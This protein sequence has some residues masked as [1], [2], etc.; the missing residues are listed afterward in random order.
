MDNEPFNAIEWI[1]ANRDSFK[2]PTGSR[3]ISQDD[4][5]MVMLLAGPNAR[6]DYHINPHGEIFHQLKGTISVGYL[7]DQGLQQEAVIDE[8]DVW[9]CPAFVPHQ[10]RRPPGTY[11]LVIE[12]PSR[13]DEIN[14]LVWYCQSCLALL[15]E[16]ETLGIPGR[17][18]FEEVTGREDWRTC[19]RCGHA[20]PGPVVGGPT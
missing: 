19:G 11:G 15:H 6:D 18:V 9:Y 8:G 20:N 17:N 5:F 14:K 10:P 16:I 3:V 7:D 4:D 12:R 1:E 13:A 2:P